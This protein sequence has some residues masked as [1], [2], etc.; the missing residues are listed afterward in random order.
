MSRRSRFD[1]TPNPTHAV[2]YSRNGVERFYRFA[3]NADDCNA[4][5]AELLSREAVGWALPY[6]MFLRRELVGQ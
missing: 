6:E 3:W 4:A 1:D 2:L 5:I